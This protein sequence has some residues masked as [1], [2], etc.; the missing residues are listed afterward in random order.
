MTDLRIGDIVR[1]SPSSALSFQDDTYTVIALDPRDGVCVEDVDGM[2]QWQHNEEFVLAVRPEK[3]FGSS[4]LVRQ[5]H[6]LEPGRYDTDKPD[7]LAAMAA[8][9]RVIARDAA[10]MAESV[11]ALVASTGTRA[12]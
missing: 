5:L 11:D 3:F 1:R 8:N 10:A 4:E 6:Q 2:A 12:A 9:L 7:D